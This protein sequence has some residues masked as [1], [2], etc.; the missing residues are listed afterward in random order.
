MNTDLNDWVRQLEKIQ[1]LTERKYILLVSDEDYWPM[2]ARV[3]HIHQVTVKPSP[4]V[5]KGAAYLV[6]DPAEVLT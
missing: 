1:H 5:K 2:L 4:F 6:P 3:V